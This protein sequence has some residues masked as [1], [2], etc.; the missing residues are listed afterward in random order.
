MYEAM[1]SDGTVPW[2]RRTLGPVDWTFLADAPPFAAYVVKDLLKETT[3]GFCYGFDMDYDEGECGF[4]DMTFWDYTSLDSTEEER[5]HAVHFWLA[6]ADEPWG[7]VTLHPVPFSF[8]YVEEPDKPPIEWKTYNFEY[9]YQG[10]YDSAEDLLAA[11]ESGEL[12]IC[13]LSTEFGFSNT[14]CF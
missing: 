5:I 7:Y 12:T 1:Y 4:D 11:Y 10:P 6:P 2:S 9:C 14:V 3:G 8:N 13:T